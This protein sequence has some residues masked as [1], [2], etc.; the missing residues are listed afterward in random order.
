MNRKF[1]FFI[2]LFALTICLTGLETVKADEFKYRLR[3]NYV[4]NY[5]QKYKFT[6]RQEVTTYILPDEN[7][8][9][10]D[11]VKYD[12]ETTMYFKLK[13]IDKPGEGVS[14]VRVIVDSLVYD[15]KSKGKDIS[16]RT[17][18]FFD[19]A[20]MLEPDYQRYGFLPEHYYSFYYSPYSEVE[21]VVSPELDEKREIFTDPT[22][23]FGTE[24]SRKRLGEYL[25]HRMVSFLFD[26]VKNIL[27]DYD[28]ERD[29]TWFADIDI[30]L[31]GVWVT[32]KV[33]Y[34]IES[35]T[36]QGYL[37]KG[38]LD[39]VIDRSLVNSEIF[40]SGLNSFGTVEKSELKGMVSAYLNT[41]SQLE[42]NSITLDGYLSGS[43]GGRK[44]N[45][46]RKTFYNWELL[47]TY[48]N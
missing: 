47:K 7:S 35:F 34:K 31:D 15:Y 45:Q 32:P 22:S 9:V 21:K 14:E 48:T 42:S 28:I 30:E 33:E 8:G 40:F 38:K 3:T 18:N 20:P 27:P 39:T 12:R 4:V 13:T 2:W 6:E 41:R 46:K 17:S 25:S 23:K 1:T 10:G 26:P 36:G 29:S 37:I 43:I 5:I 44:F 24:V 19:E 16:Y 11:S